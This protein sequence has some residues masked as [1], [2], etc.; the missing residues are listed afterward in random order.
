MS[1]A[2]RVGADRATQKPWESLGHFAMAV[3]ASDPD[4]Q[5][6]SPVPVDP[7]LYGAATGMNQTSFAVRKSGANL[8]K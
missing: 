5:R 1:S 4:L 6:Q 8:A 3:M 7:R 2:V